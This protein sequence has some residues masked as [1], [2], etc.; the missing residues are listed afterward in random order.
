[1]SIH[2]QAV[3]TQSIPYARTMH[4]SQA[5]A[6]KLPSGYLAQGADTTGQLAL[7]ETVIQPGEEPPPHIHTRE[8]EAFY[9]LEGAATF[10]VGNQTFPATTGT[11]IWLPRNIQHAFKIHS[12]RMRALVFIMPAGLERYFVLM[13]QL[14]Q[15]E[16]VKPGQIS[17]EAAKK[18]QEL[19]QQF[20]I[21]LA[22]PA[23][24]ETPHD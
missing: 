11:F 22:L 4:A 14:F 13:A 17:P 7:S 10:Y 2:E 20:G 1:M 19:S 9:L 3:N 23:A 21:T 6:S 12:G 18:W 5:T 16:N 15:Q 8:D 24:S